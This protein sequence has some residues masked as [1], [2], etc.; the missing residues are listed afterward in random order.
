MNA[1]ATWLGRIPY[2]AERGARGVD[3]SGEPET[4]DIC[5]LHPIFPH[6]ALFANSP[7][8]AHAQTTYLFCRFLS[9]LEER[10]VLSISEPRDWHQTALSARRRLAGSSRLRYAPCTCSI[11]V[12]MRANAGVAKGRSLMRGWACATSSPRMS[13]RDFSVFFF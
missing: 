8:P 3:C 1:T 11:L 4:D 12:H 5:S 13:V 2:N 6:T 10:R 7:T 9:V